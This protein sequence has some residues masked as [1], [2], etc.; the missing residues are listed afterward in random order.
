MMNV[1][2]GVAADSNLREF[3]VLLGHASRQIQE[4]LKGSTVRAEALV[5]PDTNDESFV[6]A[7]TVPGNFDRKSV[8]MLANSILDS[9]LGDFPPGYV[10]PITTSVRAFN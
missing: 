4:Q 9:L 10:P 3:E 7:V 2:S 1:K 6:L 5:D 8:K